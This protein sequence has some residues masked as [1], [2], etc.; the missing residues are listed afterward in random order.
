MN[1]I[2]AQTQT[3]FIGEQTKHHLP[4]EVLLENTHPLLAMYSS[5]GASDW[6]NNGSQNDH[7][8]IISQTIIIANQYCPSSLEITSLSLERDL[9][10]RM[11]SHDTSAIHAKRQQ[12]S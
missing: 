6:I 8:T 11:G 2:L 7:P 10:P 4:R 5:F 12:P 3:T 9:R 1:V